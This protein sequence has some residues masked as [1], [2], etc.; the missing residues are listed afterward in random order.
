[1]KSSIPKLNL[2]DKLSRQT[3]L[4]YPFGDLICFL[5]ECR[6]KTHEIVAPSPECK[7]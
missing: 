4:Q 2:E 3:L 5:V 6:T 7:E 1:M